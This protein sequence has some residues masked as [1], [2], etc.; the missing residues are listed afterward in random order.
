MFNIMYVKKMPNLI[1]VCLEYCTGIIL[2]VLCVYLGPLG[3]K[4]G[5]IMSH[6]EDCFPP[7][8]CLLLSQ[9]TRDIPAGFFPDGGDRR[10]LA[11]AKSKIGFDTCVKLGSGCIANT[12]LV[13]VDTVEY[14]LKVKRYN[15]ENE[16][17]QSISR[18]A[19]AAYVLTLFLKHIPIAELLEKLNGIRDMLMRQANF[20]DELMNQVYFYET[21]NSNTL[22][23]PKPHVEWSNSSVIVM[24]YIRGVPM[25]RVP[26]VERVQYA[27]ILWDFTFKATFID[28]YWHADLHK[29]NI[30]LMNDGRLGIIDFG[31]VGHFSRME[32]VVLFNYTTSLVKKM[33]PVAARLYVTRMTKPA[34]GAARSTS[35]L[36]QKNMF[37]KEVAQ[38]LEANFDTTE[39]HFF[40]SISKISECSRRYNTTFNNRH[41]EFELAFATLLGTLIELNGEKNIM[42]FLLESC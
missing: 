39:P 33:W 5:Q 22:A 40:G 2:R 14:V 23:I 38:I 11:K 25:E 32:K 41:V 18:M 24:D 26:K 3:I 7:R 42:A 1:S 8:I 19:N 29:G 35:G 10:L 13:R 4:I 28:G 31:L 34:H 27:Q 6:R 9:L 20:H 17:A 30:I 12:Y 36:V 15:I 21:Y 37:I 16:I